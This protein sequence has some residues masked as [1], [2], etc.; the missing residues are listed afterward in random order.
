MVECYGCGKALDVGGGVNPGYH[1]FGG[2]QRCFC[3]GRFYQSKKPCL[4]K[5]FIRLCDNGECPVC[6]ERGASYGGPCLDCE[7]TLRVGRVTRERVT[8]LRTEVIGE[9][10]ASFLRFDSYGDGVMAWPF[11]E[12][13]RDGSKQYILSLELRRYL[14]QLWGK[15]GEL[16]HAEGVA[17]GSDM[18][19]RLHSGEL[20]LTAHADFKKQTAEKV[21]YV[22]RELQ[23]LVIEVV[24][25]AQAIKDWNDN[26][27][28]G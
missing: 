25:R 27:E 13:T 10:L 4:T 12:V 7:K 9:I 3:P 1:W 2:K 28:K 8:D 19:A 14:S 16:H 26:R 11:R 24:E 17:K 21:P 23:K 6:G 20:A 15:W 18:L 22:K 5:A